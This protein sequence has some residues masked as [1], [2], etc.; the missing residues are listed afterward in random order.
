LVPPKLFI[1]PFAGIP[2]GGPS[3]RGANGDHRQEN[4]G[5]NREEHLQSLIE[6]ADLG[7]AQEPHEM[8]G[9]E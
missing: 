2:G 8:A 3:M 4:E 7:R 6:T 1:S 9:H 5:A